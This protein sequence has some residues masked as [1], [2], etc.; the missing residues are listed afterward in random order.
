MADEIELKLSL[1][2]AQLE[3]LRRHPFVRMIAQGRAKRRRLVGTYFDSEDF[4]LR[5][6]RMALRLRDVGQ[7]R[8]QTLKIAPASYA[9]LLAGRG[10]GG[11]R[12]PAASPATV[13]HL[14][15]YETVTESDGPDIGLIEDEALRDFFRDER[16][17]ERL[18]PVF[19]TDIDRR[20]LL[21]RHAD[22]EIELALDIGEIHAGGRSEAVSEAE[23]ELKSGPP[24]RL[25][26]LAL[27]LSEQLP[28]RLEAR[29]KAER[30]YALYE[31]LAPTPNRGRKP[32]LQ[33]GMTVSEA[34]ALLAGACLEQ[35]RG[36]ESAVLAGADPEGVHQLRVA[37]RRLRALVSLMKTVLAPDAAAFLKE[38]LRWLQQSLGPA[39]DWDVFGIGTLK[40]LA[41]RLPNEPSLGGLEKAV[42]AARAQAY[43]DAQA[44]LADVRY[45]RLLLRLAL[46]L[47][48]GGWH[49]R[50][51]FGEPD[52]A[53]RPIT[54]LADALL[55]RRDKALRRTA[56][57]RKGRSE[58]E[59]HEVRIAAKKLRYAVEFFRGLYGSKAVK[60]HLVRLVALQDTLGTL[61]DAVVGHRLI[62]ELEA[63]GAQDRKRAFEPYAAGLVIGWQAARIE[64]DLGHFAAA[65]DDY[66]KARPFWGR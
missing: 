5:D 33:P 64:A 21:L 65:W 26:E 4:L 29:S 8:L 32:E 37:L 13:Q 34:F 42:E 53:G 20:T 1:P 24:A 14:I 52:P 41:R 7:Q 3:K 57:K 19:S 23:L 11:G 17:A 61:N 36:N 39:R 30:G 48:E 40:P 28:F 58:A 59:L 60:R 22:A 45:S 9:A 25:Y 12:A 55:S 63:A 62:D 43:R 46:W 51:E 35:M 16:L 6:R 49:R 10:L 47:Q 15:E 66:R 54:E 31:Q 27:L 56:R 2:P 18:E 38:E 50:P 44:A